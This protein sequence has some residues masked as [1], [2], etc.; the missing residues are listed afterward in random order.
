MDGREPTADL[1][2]VVEYFERFA[3]SDANADR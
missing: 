1:M 2:R 3:E